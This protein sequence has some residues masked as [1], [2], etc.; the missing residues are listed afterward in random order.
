MKLPGVDKYFTY[1]EL[2][3][4]YIDF[5]K[6]D[7]PEYKWVE[8]LEEKIMFVGRFSQLQA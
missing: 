4:F 8:F 3:H 6:M 1:S 5:R 2:Y 7:M